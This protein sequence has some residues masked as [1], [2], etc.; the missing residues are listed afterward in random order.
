MINEKELELLR[1]DLNRNTPLNLSMLGRVF[2]EEFW[3]LIVLCIT[4]QD[5]RNDK[6][7]II[8]NINEKQKD[9]K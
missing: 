5:I 3:Q 1:N 2:G 8:I 9:A 4:N 6:G 7:N